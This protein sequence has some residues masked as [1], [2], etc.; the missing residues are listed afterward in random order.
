MSLQNKQTELDE[1][2]P[3]R[4]AFVML[5]IGIIA[6]CSFVLYSIIFYI[7]GGWLLPPYIL[8]FIFLGGIGII[9]GSFRIV[10]GSLVTKQFVNATLIKMRNGAIAGSAT[11]LVVLQIAR[12]SVNHDSWQN[13]FN[14]VIPSLIIDI[15]GALFF[16]ISAG[17]IG[18]L[19]LGN[20]WENN[21][22]AFVGGVI[23]GVTTSFLY[24]SIYIRSL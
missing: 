7:A 12:V 13:W 17:G 4:L 1:A 21:K 20:I 15:P 6:V 16:G 24:I 18:G 14:G 8:P 23:A 10:R 9:Y 11:A 2:R 3:D 22:A 19:I 5:I